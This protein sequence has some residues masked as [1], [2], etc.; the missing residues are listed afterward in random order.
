VPHRR[1]S[2]ILALAHKLGVEA[3]RLSVLSSTL[4]E[5]R[6]ALNS[7]TRELLICV[8]LLLGIWHLLSD[9]LSRLISSLWR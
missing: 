4:Q 5:L 1:K 2:P 7:L 3:R 9:T 8:A 6:K